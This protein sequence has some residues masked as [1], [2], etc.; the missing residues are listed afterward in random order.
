M[1]SLLPSLLILIS[2]FTVE[3]Q[4]SKKIQE[5]K[6]FQQTLNSEFADPEESPLTAEDL[7]K[8]KELTFF[9]IDTNYVIE[10]EF[11][12]TP[13]ES[14]FAM[15]TTT[16]RTPIY[17]KYGKAYFKIKG[18][19][20]KLN[21]Y[22]SQDLSTNPEYLD[23]LFIPFTDESNGHGSYPGG[24]Y[25]DFKIPTSN[26]ITLDFNKAYNPYC[27]YSGRYSCPIPPAENNL[28]VAIPVGVKYFK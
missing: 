28:A 14:P 9:E 5:I 3:A 16:N 11:V 19:S 1:K 8:F 6:D 7:K 24:R 22:Q 21:I 4:N 10:A 18:K 23:Y 12:R 20:Y 27:A 13:S 26:R 25:I 2:I 15:P 17:V